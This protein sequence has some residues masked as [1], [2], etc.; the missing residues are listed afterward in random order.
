L[1]SLI[2]HAHDV[3]EQYAPSSHDEADAFVL[4]SALLLLQCVLRFKHPAFHEERERRIL[5]VDKLDNISPKTAFRWRGND[6]V[7]YCLLPFTP[8]LITR[9]LHAPGSASRIND[10]SLPRMLQ[11]LVFGQTVVERSDIPIR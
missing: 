3:F 11:S 5:T 1:Q 7:P 9:I 10:Q 6:L 4:E 2:A 8:D